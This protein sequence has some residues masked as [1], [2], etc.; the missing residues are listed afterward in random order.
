MIYKNPQGNH[1]SSNIP[2]HKCSRMVYLKR[3]NSLDDSPQKDEEAQHSVF[4][5]FIKYNL[6]YINHEG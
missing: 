1:L 4:Q 5:Y 2:P 3:Y 6:L